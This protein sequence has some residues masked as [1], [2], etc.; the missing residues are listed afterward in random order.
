[1]YLLEARCAV[2]AVYCDTC[3]SYAGDSSE[4]PGTMQCRSCP[5]RICDK[6]GLLDHWGSG[7][8]CGCF[9]P[10]ETVSMADPKA[11][12]ARHGCNVG[13]D[14]RITSGNSDAK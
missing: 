14:G 2:T 11:T 13:T 3:D 12:F 9:Q 5:P 1:M 6:C 8:Y 4:I 7:T 10:V